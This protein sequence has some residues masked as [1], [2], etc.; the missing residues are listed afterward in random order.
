[1][2]RANRR[3]AGATCAVRLCESHVVMDFYA[4]V[5]QLQAARPRG[6]SIVTM[7]GRS[8]QGRTMKREDQTT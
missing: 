2:E 3:T 8:S 5:V 6:S 1:M 7:D 4:F